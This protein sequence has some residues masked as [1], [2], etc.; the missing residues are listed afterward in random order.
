MTHCIDV[1]L[2]P[3][4]TPIITGP[5]LVTTGQTG[6]QY[7]TANVTGHLYSWSV[8][9]GNVTGGQGTNCI[10]IDWTSTCQNCQ[11][12]VVVYESFNG[13][14]GIDTLDVNIIPGA[15]NLTGYVTYDNSYNT[16]L[17]GVAVQ[18]FNAGGDLIS[19]VTTGPNTY[20][21]NEPGFFAFSDI[22]DGNYRIKAHSTGEFG[23]NNATDALIIQLNIIG[24]YPLSGFRGLAADVNASQN[25]TALDALYI[26]LRTVGMITSYPAGDWLFTDT[27]FT[28]AS[29]AGINLKGICFGDVNG[30]YI[31]NGFKETSFLSPMEDGIMTI[32]VNESFN[33]EI[34]S[35]AVSEIGAMTLFMDFDQTKFTIE[36]V[37]TNLD[38]MKYVIGN[39]Q[40]SIAWSDIKPLTLKPNDPVL[41]F[42][43][44]AFKPVTEPT[45]IFSIRAGS[46]FADI[47]AS[48]YDNYEIKMAHVISTGS[49]SRFDMINYPNPFRNTTT[50]VYTMP[51]AGHV[52]LVLTDM[53]GKQIRT[54]VSEDQ[55][56]GIHKVIVDP[57]DVNLTSGVYL[58]KIVVE[59]TS[60]TYTKVNKML[61][62]R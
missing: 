11:G 19:T 17:N 47:N 31:P 10:T 12:K 22:P 50:I 35:N 5:I 34:R 27:T 14:C 39:G 54:L 58:Y 4:P 24:S 33:Y 51:E 59:G 20:S 6:T 1:T 60:D 23:G 25:V 28:L 37:N 61:F 3:L 41:S 8:I 18:L 21:A 48:K 57:F 43:L 9:G 52:N 30:S 56:A 46:E 7:C 38:G 13:C 49:D 26:K 55:M 15:G 40:V 2:K 32:P 29:S 42:Q 53:F 16:A 62:T 44:K 36:K 45:Q